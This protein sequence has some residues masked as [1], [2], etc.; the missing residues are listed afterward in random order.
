MT[1]SIFTIERRKNFPA[2]FSK[3]FEDLQSSVTTSTGDSYKMF[4]FLDHCL[5]YWPHRC[6][7]TGIDDYLNSTLP[8]S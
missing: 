8:T 2:A 7:A 4:A 1:V 6:G 3:F 5:R